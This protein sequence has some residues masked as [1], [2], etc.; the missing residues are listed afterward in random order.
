MLLTFFIIFTQMIG[1]EIRAQLQNIIRGT[2]IE[3]QND[4][5]TTIKNLL[6][7][8]FGTSPTVKS[9]FESRAILK[10]KQA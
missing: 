9:E 4:H 1:D 2:L 7:K 10:E 5:C 8:S 3:G 6:V